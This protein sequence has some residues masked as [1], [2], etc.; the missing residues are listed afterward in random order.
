ML[1]SSLKK[2]I[3]SDFVV[4]RIKWKIS[5]RKIQR[6]EPLEFENNGNLL[7][8]TRI[9]YVW[10]CLWY[11]FPWNYALKSASLDT[12]FFLPEFPCFIIIK[13]LLEAFKSFMAHVI[14]SF[15][16]NDLVISIWR[17]VVIDFFIS[18]QKIKISRKWRKYWKTF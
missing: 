10:S 9:W 6:S 17:T 12:F 5:S 14:L 2:K 15:G 3:C 1:Y 18:K 13:I 8:V 16:K 4:S 7:K 11:E